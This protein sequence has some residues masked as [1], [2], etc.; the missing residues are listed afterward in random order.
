MILCRWLCDA[1]VYKTFNTDRR[2]INPILERVVLDGRRNSG[3]RTGRL[4]HQD[5]LEDV[6]EINSNNQDVIF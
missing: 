4:M 5:S 1:N 2:Q 6:P 3:S